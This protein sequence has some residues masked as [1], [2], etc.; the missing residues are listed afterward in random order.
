MAFRMTR[1]PEQ[2]R[3]L[4]LAAILFISY[5]CVAVALPVVPVHVTATLGLGNGW[6]GFGVGV[7]FLATILSRG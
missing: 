3:L 6:A 7:A 5:L 2:R 4:L 1:D